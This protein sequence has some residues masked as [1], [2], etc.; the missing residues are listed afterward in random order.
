MAQDPCDCQ[1]TGPSTACMQSCGH[2]AGVWPNSRG[3]WGKAA[4]YTVAWPLGQVTKGAMF[5]SSLAPSAHR[6]QQSTR[7][8]PLCPVPSAR[9]GQCCRPSALCGL[10]EGEFILAGLPQLSAHQALGENVGSEESL[11][12]DAGSS[13]DSSTF[14]AILR[15]RGNTSPLQGLG[16][17]SEPCL[18]GTWSVLWCMWVLSQLPHLRVKMIPWLSDTS[19]LLLVTSLAVFCPTVPVLVFAEPFSR[20]RTCASS[21]SVSRLSPTICPYTGTVGLMGGL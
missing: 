2:G 9:C 18:K 3:L 12:G 11:V 20:G 14:R 16:M 7:Q 4:R 19:G 15:R 13:R 17:L 5:G 8:V 6:A 1:G 10:W 21:T